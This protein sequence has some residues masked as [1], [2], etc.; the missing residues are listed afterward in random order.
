MIDLEAAAKAILDQLVA[1]QPVIANVEA[2]YVAIIHHRVEN[3]QSAT[4]LVA[5]PPVISP[6]ILHGILDRV[7]EESEETRTIVSIMGHLGDASTVEKIVSMY[8]SWSSLLRQIAFYS[9]TDIGGLSA[10]IALSKAAETLTGKEQDIALDALLR[11]ASVDDHA[12]Q[13]GGVMA[14]SLEALDYWRKHRETLASVLVGEPIARIEAIGERHLGLQPRIN[15]VVDALVTTLYKP[16][17]QARTLAWMQSFPDIPPCRH[18]GRCL[19]AGGPCCQGMAEDIAQTRLEE[20][21]QVRAASKAR[22]EIKR[23]R[24]LV[25]R[26]DR[27]A[28]LALGQPPPAKEDPSSGT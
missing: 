28:A 17:R 18:C 15:V 19:L 3:G 13:E 16:L 6:A 24:K 22:H 11:L 25:R 27:R 4:L 12:F 1:G 9:L 7:R 23:Q 5:R 8:P 2:L 26:A 14:P 20:E 10:T 21:A